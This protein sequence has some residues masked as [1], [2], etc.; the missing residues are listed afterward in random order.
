MSTDPSRSV[1]SVKSVVSESSLN[2]RWRMLAGSTLVTM[3]SNPI[4]SIY[5][6]GDLSPILSPTLYIL[7]DCDECRWNY[8]NLRVPGSNPGGFGN[9]AVA[10]LVE[11]HDAF[12]HYLSSQNFRQSSALTGALNFA[13][14]LICGA[15][16][17]GGTT[18]D[19]EVSGC[20]SRN[21]ET[22]WLRKE[23]RTCFLNHL[24][25]RDY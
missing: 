17:A 8:I 12:H 16:N 21:A 2:L 19:P 11:H 10:Q 14:A 20:E 25:S 15:T 4:S 23:R 6:G 22:H 18:S 13:C 9:N 24:S 5:C 7:Q 3:G 1:A